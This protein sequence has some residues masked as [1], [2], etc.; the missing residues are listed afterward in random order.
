[1]I[2]LSI[3]T[4]V[5]FCLWNYNGLIFSLCFRFW[6]WILTGLLSPDSLITGLSIKD[7]I[8][9]RKSPFNL[10]IT[11]SVVTIPISDL[12]L[13]TLCIVTVHPLKERQK[14]LYK[15][16]SLSVGNKNSKTIHL[17]R[18]GTREIVETLGSILLHHSHYISSYNLDTLH[19]DSL[20][21]SN[22]LYSL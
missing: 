19:T 13:N 10:G 8:W 15:A 20:C 11:S 6:V 14:W 4:L 1:M 17:K 9:R 18:D 2:G 21:N 3:Q 16:G 22:I 12:G 5:R 7:Q